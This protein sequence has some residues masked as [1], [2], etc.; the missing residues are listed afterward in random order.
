MTEQITIEAKTFSQV[1][2]A[3]ELAMLMLDAENQPPQFTPSEAYQVIKAA[4]DALY[5][6]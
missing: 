1:K 3:L 2:D 5:L 6:S 4:R